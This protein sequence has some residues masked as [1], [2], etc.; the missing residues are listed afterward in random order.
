MFE[1]IIAPENIFAA[2]REF[3]QGKMRKPDVLVFAERVEEHLLRLADDLATGKYIHGEYSRFVVHD[4]KRR[5]IAKAPVHDRVLHHAV[6]RVLAPLFDRSFI[7][8][9]YSSRVGKGTHAAGVRFRRFAGQLSHNHTRTVWVLQLDIR[10]F[11]DSVD[12][13]V[14]LGLL[15][16][17][18]R[19]DRVIVLLG[20]IIQSFETKPGQGI[21]LGNLTS[22]LFSNVYLDPLDQFAKRT[23]GVKHYLRYADDIAILSCDREFLED[24]RDRIAA[25]LTRELKLVLHPDKVSLRPWHA[26][27]D[28]LGYVHFPYYVVLRTITKRRLLARTSPV[29]LASSLGV[30]HH[31]R[32]F[33]IERAMR[34]ILNT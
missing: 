7:H 20:I 11:F 1:R 6:H 14:L 19:D 9:S 4:P 10:K 25:F 5:A 23:L 30:T 33:G 3:R 22:Q 12:H 18:I 34:D 13:Q 26:G 24:C 15:R 31:I 29:N 17:K 27:I 32:G 8:D 28:F 2:W 21:P 16:K